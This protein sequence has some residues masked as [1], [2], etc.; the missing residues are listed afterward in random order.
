MKSSKKKIAVIGAGGLASEIQWLIGDLKNYSFEGFYVTS[1]EFESSKTS[2]NVQDLKNKIETGLIDC[3]VVGVGDPKTRQEIFEKVSLEIK[4]ISW[5]TLIHPSVI[6][7]KKTSTVDSGSIICAGSIIT[8]NV[9]ISKNC[10][11]NLHSTVGHDTQIGSHCVVNPGSNISGN[12]II[13]NSTLVGTGSSIIQKIRVGELVTIGASACVTKSIE[14][15]KTVVGVP[16][17]E[18]KK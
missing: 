5:E 3:V 1:S 11:I 15:G 7:D 12:V 18:I 2:G 10:L 6:L 17:K 4:N 16:A 8:T 13:G 9:R 14:N